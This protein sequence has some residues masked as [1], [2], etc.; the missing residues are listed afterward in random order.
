MIT[1]IDYNETEPR[2]TTVALVKERLAIQDTDTSRDD[3]IKTAIVSAELAMDVWMGRALPDT[4]DPDDPAVI[5]I[6]PSAVQ[7]AALSMSIALWNQPD[8]IT[9][10]GSDAFG[11][12]T[13]PENIIGQYLTR[14]PQMVGLRVTWGIA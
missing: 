3:E 5:T 8:S 4:E 14:A 12:G 11:F 1:P 13:I 9:G 10:G 7:S 6:I 2:Y